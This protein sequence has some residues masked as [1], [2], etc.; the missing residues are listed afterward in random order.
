MNYLKIIISDT[1][2]TFEAANGKEALKLAMEIVP[3]I[4][5]TDV[6][7]PDMNGL[8]FCRALK[9]QTATSHIPVIML[10]SQWDDSMQVSGYEAGTDVYLTKPVKKD[11]LLQ[12]VLLAPTA[13]RCCRP[14]VGILVSSLFAPICQDRP[15][16]I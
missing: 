2:E 13:R 6:L 1:F 7:M 9:S 16:R 4:V 3:A 14:R 12:D 10:T 15:R 11:L 8:E 5:I